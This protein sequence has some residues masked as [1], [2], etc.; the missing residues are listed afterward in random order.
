MPEY[1]GVNK[2]FSERAQRALIEMAFSHDR[3]HVESEEIPIV[4]NYG[5]I[6]IG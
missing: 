1:T 4:K 3:K 6:L 5:D 2:P